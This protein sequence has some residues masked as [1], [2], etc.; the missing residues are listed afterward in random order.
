MSLDE[1]N[2][3]SEAPHAA[4][5]EGSTSPSD[6]VS[7]KESLEA[8]R[9]ALKRRSIPCSSGVF[10]LGAE[11]LTL[12]YGKKNAGTTHRVDFDPATDKEIEA[13]AK[14][15]EPA[16]FGRN[17]EAILDET[18]RKAGKM[19]ATD[20][21]TKFDPVSCRLLDTLREAL[22]EGHDADRSIRAELYKLN[23]YGPGSFFKPHKDTPRAGNM[24]ATLVVV[25]PTP[26]K[27][28]ALAFRHGDS[29]YIFDSAA[30]IADASEPSIAFAAFYSDV[31]H[32]VTPVEN[33]HRVTLTYNLYFGARPKVPF[34]VPMAGALETSLKASMSSLLSNATFLPRGGYI[35]FGLSH[36]YPVSEGYRPEELKDFLK[37]SDAVLLHVCDELSLDVNIKVAYKNGWEFKDAILCDFTL[38]SIDEL[39]DG[40]Q[41]LREELQRRGGKQLVSKP[42]IADSDE[43]AGSGDDEDSEEDCDFDFPPIFVRWVTPLVDPCETKDETMF[44]GNMGNEPGKEWMYSSMCLLVDVPK[45]SERLDPDA[46]A[47]D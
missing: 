41:S 2:I 34:T 38:N 4:P 28:G 43:A 31:E 7:A 6:K 17:N 36:L 39:Y 15:C 42:A 26:H 19:D 13:L 1:Q 46:E 3:P 35:G 33:G 27:G 25:L 30:A 47:E 40:I 44:V 23:V 18:Y 8:V 5:M 16:S 9:H 32:E 12:F 14:A 20:F 37:G 10:P 24:F 11:D 21:C 29:E 45:L 22:L